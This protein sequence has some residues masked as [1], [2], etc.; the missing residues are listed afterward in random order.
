MKEIIWWADITISDC[1]GN[2][3]CFDDLN[4]KDRVKITDAIRRGFEHGK[5]YIDT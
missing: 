3:V 5:I 1:E 2:D 4:D